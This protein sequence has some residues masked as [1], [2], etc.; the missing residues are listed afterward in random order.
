MS[1]I[2]VTAP[3]TPSA[4]PSRPRRSTQ[5]V[6]YSYKPT[7]GSEDESSAGEAGE[8]SEKAKGKRRAVSSDDG[9]D[10][11][12]EAAD[13]FVAPEESSSSDDAISL[14]GEVVEEEDED[15]SR[16]GVNEPDDDE[17]EIVPVHSPS[18]SPKIRRSAPVP[19]KLKKPAAKP[20]FASLPA[21]ASTVGG[22][23]RAATRGGRRAAPT[24]GRGTRARNTAA[25]MADCTPICEPDTILTLRHPYW[26]E[27]H[28]PGGGSSGLMIQKS[29]GS[30]V[31]MRV[32]AC[33][34]ALPVNPTWELLED[35]EHFPGRLALRA[36][37]GGWHED[38]SVSKLELADAECV[39]LFAPALTSQAGPALPA[40]VRGRES[41]D[42]RLRGR[43]RVA[44]R[45]G[46]GRRADGRRRRG[47]L[48]DGLAHCPHGSRRLERQ[49]CRPGGRHV[50]A[51]PVAATRCVEK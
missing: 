31:R 32:L 51:L 26:H 30:S 13:T 15:E 3:P 14:V 11:E 49:R 16:S 33:W 24:T 10:D 7:F 43:G 28:A 40:R 2:D 38:A 34:R 48:S 44:E 47:R 25:H 39:S 18:G 46:V 35:L 21:R 9:F 17:D 50:R 23:A 1:D 37:W 22:S 5:N 20:T 4:G 45:R 29:L 8:P 19:V 12:A 41:A 36:R 42:A 6:S 27:S